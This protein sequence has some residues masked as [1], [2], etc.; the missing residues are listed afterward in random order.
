MKAFRI[1]DKNTPKRKNKEIISDPVIK[2]QSF[3]DKLFG[4][5]IRR[6]LNKK[7]GFLLYNC[8]SIHTFWMRYS[9]DVIFL[10]KDGEVL[11]IFNGLK[12][13]RVTPFIKN[14]SHALE[15]MSGSVDKNSLGTGDTI[16]F[17]N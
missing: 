6:K 1:S 15:M 8:N 11:A 9:I 2:A 7:E 5:T 14:A 12:P 4:L 16:Q 10:D 13:F 3:L 17:G